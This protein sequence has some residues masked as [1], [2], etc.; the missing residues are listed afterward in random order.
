M[1][2]ERCLHAN[3]DKCVYCM[4]RVKPCKSITCEFCR[5]N[6]LFFV[7][8][9]REEWSKD[10]I[11]FPDEVWKGSTKK[12][13]LVCRNCKREY[14]QSAC[15]M[16][17]YGCSMCNNKT[18]VKLFMFLKEEFNCVESQLKFEWS[19]KFS[20]DFKVNNVLIELDGPQHFKLINSWRS[21]W[22]TMN[23]DVKK[24]ELALLNNFNILRVTQKSVAE[25]KGDWKKF[26][27]SEIA[28]MNIQKKC[29]VVTENCKEYNDGIYKRLR[30]VN[31]F[32]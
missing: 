29:R 5:T 2:C 17:K 9:L 28:K 3:D 20:Y 24:E 13:K 26:L 4:K 22:D 16:D 25:D 1:K 32:F 15:R 10:N 19:G 30:V 12:Y 31:C 8:R 18:E 21:G 23:N 7:K 6:S 11:I 14:M 27:S